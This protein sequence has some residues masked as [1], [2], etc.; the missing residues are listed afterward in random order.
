MGGHAAAGKTLAASTRSLILEFMASARACPRR[1]SFS[2]LTVADCANLKC[3][4]S[5][6]PFSTFLMAFLRFR[7]FSGELELDEEEKELLE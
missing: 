2:S 3:L 7:A 1:R 6:S 4:Y 5:G